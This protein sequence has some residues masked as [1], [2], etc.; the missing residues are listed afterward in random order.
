MVGS[1]RRRR[2]HLSLLSMLRPRL[3]TTDLRP[4][5]YQRA[6]T[7]RKPEAYARF[8]FELRLEENFPKKFSPFLN[9]GHCVFY[10]YDPGPL[11]QNAGTRVLS[12]SVKITRVESQCLQIRTRTCSKG[13]SISLL[14]SKNHAGQEKNACLLKVKKK[15]VAWATLLL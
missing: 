8:L 12:P 9:V 5:G 1:P 7:S 6:T 11:G 4:N 15:V 2:S 10:R 13:Y 3:V 14:C